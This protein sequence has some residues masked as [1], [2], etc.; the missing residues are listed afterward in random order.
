[1]N[2]IRQVR[3][4]LVWESKAEPTSALTGSRLRWQE[5]LATY[6]EAREFCINNPTYSLGFCFSPD[7]NFIGFDIDGCRNPETGEITDWGQE[8]LDQLP[9]APFLNNSISG[10]GIKVILRCEDEITRAVRN[11]DNVDAFGDHSPQVELFVNSKYFA[12]TAQEVPELAGWGKL[13][14]EQV[15]AIMNTE[16][17][18]SNS[19]LR[20]ETGG[21]VPIAHLRYALGKLDITDFSSRDRWL[22]MLQGAHHSCGGSEEGYMAFKEWSEGDA[23]CFNEADLERDWDSMGESDNPITFGSILHQLDPSDWPQV[24]VEDQFDVL[25]T[26]ERVVDGTQPIPAL[27]NSEFR[28]D[29][30]IV[31]LFVRESGNN[32]RWNGERKQWL[33]WNGSLWNRTKDDSMVLRE[34]VQWVITLPRRVPINTEEPEA[35]QRAVGF[36]TNLANATPLNNLKTVLKSHQDVAIRDEDLDANPDKLNCLNGTLNL[37]TQTLEPFNKD[38]LI[39]MTVDTN[40]VDNAKRLNWDDTLQK[41]F[42][43]DKELIAYFQRCMGYALLGSTKEELMLIL[44]GNGANGKS[45]VTQTLLKM[46]NSSLS[47][48]Y[49]TS[50]SSKLLDGK[51]ELHDQYFARMQ[52]KRLALFSELEADIPLNEAT[53]KKLCSQDEIE[54]RYMRENSFT[55]VPTHLAMLCTNHKPSVSGTDDGIWRRLR[56]I[57][58][59]ANLNHHG[60]DVDMPEKLKAEY[61][62]ILNWC[63]E[64]LKAYQAH[65]IGTCTAVEDATD[66]YRDSEDE[67]SEVFSQLFEE[68]TDNIV[69]ATDA[70]KAYQSIGGFLTRKAFAKEMERRGH[71][72]KQYNRTLCKGRGYIN[73]NLLVSGEGL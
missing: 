46:F 64:G 34:L 40:H 13:G 51:K 55:F 68:K 15:E 3:Q 73:L 63:V 2:D 42:C 12:I 57:P 41:V 9:I 35:S 65:G 36:T 66:T 18:P 69:S 32:I 14:I 16:L 4:W 19:P 59:A 29:Y 25:P 5:N 39:T 37:K 28:N 17:S 52:N 48:G 38:D 47:D 70:F 54:A 6:A 43:G 20:Q 56:L 10:T 60:K 11:Y 67:F 21:N 58:F 53:V 1:M 26:P 7:S 61:A 62:G 72:N 24:A 22:I 49:A 50:L 23:S 45:T 33:V 71:F 27:L 44:Y 30:H 31:D 8:I